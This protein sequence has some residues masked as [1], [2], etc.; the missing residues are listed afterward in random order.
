MPSARQGCRASCILAIP[1]PMSLFLC[2][3]CK[4]CH[5]S[6]RNAGRNMIH[7]VPSHLHSFQLLA[8][9]LN[10]SP[11]WRER[12][13]PFPLSSIGSLYC[14]GCSRRRAGLTAFGT[15]TQSRPGSR[16][17]RTPENHHHLS[18]GSLLLSASL[19]TRPTQFVSKSISHHII[20]HSVPNPPV[21]TFA[22]NKDLIVSLPL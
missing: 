11:S 18:L 12:H 16:M 6:H 9:A 3:L 8:F 14:L 10:H 21:A 2:L 15:N 5:Q 19:V 20:C 7:L 17:N 1:D 13:V 22:C 4:S